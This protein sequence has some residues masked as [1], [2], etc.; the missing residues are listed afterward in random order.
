TA[1]WV[2][3]LRGKTHRIHLDPIG[4]ARPAFFARGAATQIR[5]GHI[6]VP[7]PK[8]QGQTAR[9]P[10]KLEV[11]RRRALRATQRRVELALYSAAAKDWRDFQSWRRAHL[12]YCRCHRPSIFSARHRHRVF[13]AECERLIT[14]VIAEQQLQMP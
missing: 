8:P 14:E 3:D 12:L 1:R 2:A 7:V 6:T 5:R 10:R 4:I 11:L 9:L 13:I